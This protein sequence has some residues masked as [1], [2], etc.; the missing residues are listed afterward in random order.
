MT[1]IF[2]TE[3]LLKIITLGFFINGKESYLRSSW[4]ILDFVI[5]IFAVVSQTV[6]ANISFIKVLR[7]ARIL[8]PLRLI[9]RAQGLKI[10]VKSLFKAFP[11]IIRLQIVV[12]F[13]I[14]MISILMTTL[15]SGKFHRCDL[16][17]TSLSPKQ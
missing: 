12:L 3:A 11:Q 14:F 4:N 10:A 5:V 8:R 16:E 17:H 13:V 6:D 1:V 7:V 15:L 2:A 9:S